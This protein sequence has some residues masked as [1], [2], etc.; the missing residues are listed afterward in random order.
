[1][2]NINHINENVIHITKNKFF[3]PSLDGLISV[4][5]DLKTFESEFRFKDSQ[6]DL[7]ITIDKDEF[8]KLLMR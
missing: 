7:E 2:F 1:M 6:K 5:I 3:K 4:I 8:E